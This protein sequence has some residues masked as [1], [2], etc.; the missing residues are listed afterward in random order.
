[1][2][3]FQ[4]QFTVFSSK[5]KQVNLPS[6]V[7]I[8]VQRRRYGLSTYVKAS[9]PN[10]VVEGLCGNFNGN[11][12]DEFGGKSLLDFTKLNRYK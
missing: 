1:M 9:K 11:K 2:H 4:I 3:N 5:K 10:N 6:G 7:V 12:D 8:S